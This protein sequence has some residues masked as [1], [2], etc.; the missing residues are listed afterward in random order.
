MAAE[1]QAAEGWT[2]AQAAFIVGEDPQTF[3]KVVDRTPV[4]PRIVDRDGVRVRY[5]AMADLVYIHALDELTKA[6]TT[7]SR[8]A[9]YDALRRAPKHGVRE[10]VFGEHKYAIHRHFKSVE[11]RARKLEQLSRH[12]D[13][14]KGEALIKGTGI[15]AYRIAAL[16]DGGMTMAEVL[17]DYPSLKEEQALAAKAYADA[18]PKPGRPFPKTTAKAAARKVDLSALDAFADPRE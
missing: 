6:Y 17:G 12:I 18:N 8:A 5:F 2:T 13:T 15:E 7:K 1:A 16:L 3:T 4:K 10:I 11:A 9:L 14:S